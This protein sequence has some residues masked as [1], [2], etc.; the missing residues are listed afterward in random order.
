MTHRNTPAMIRWATAF[1]IAAAPLA[2]VAQ[3]EVSVIAVD[4]AASELGNDA[5]TFRFTRTGPTTSALAVSVDFEPTTTATSQDYGDNNGGQFETFGLLTIPAG[6]SQLDIIITPTPDNLVEGDERLDIAI[7]DGSYVIG[8]PNTAGI[9]IADDAPV[10]SIAATQPVGVEGGAPAVVRFSRAGGQISQALSLA[11]TIDPISTATSADYTDNNGG[12]FQTFGL[13]SIPAAQPFFDL[14]LSPVLDAEVD[15]EE[16]LVIE[17]DTG[18]YVIGEPMSATVTFIE[19]PIFEDGFEVPEVN[20]TTCGVIESAQRLPER[21]AGHGA[22]IIDIE[23]GIEWR[24]CRATASYDWD[25]EI[26]RNDA[27]SPT[28]AKL[29]EGEMLDALNDGVIAD[30]HGFSDWRRATKSE[31]EELELPVQRCV[32]RKTGRK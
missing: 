12:Q 9:V 25:S 28:N 31:L 11:T 10:V 21:F 22:S 13:L 23:T 29:D 6:Q 18:S 19:L 15:E 17:L 5:A 24:R 8:T 30:N 4:S 20:K 3:V 14:V 27:G 26:C 16:I 7:A 32:V 2:T 1:L